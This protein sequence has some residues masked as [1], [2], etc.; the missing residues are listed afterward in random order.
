LAKVFLDRETGVTNYILIPKVVW[1]TVEVELPDD[2][3]QA[4]EKVRG[5]QAILN[6]YLSSVYESARANSPLPPTTE[7]VQKVIDS[8]AAP[9]APAP[10]KKQKQQ[11][12]AAASS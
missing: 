2:V 3:V 5:M 7:D 1:Y 12:S 6:Q 11:G 4:I 8:C 10:A 9:A